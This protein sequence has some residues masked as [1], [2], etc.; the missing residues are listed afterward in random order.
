M[1]ENSPARLWSLRAAY[2]GLAL[3][4]FFVHLLPMRI[5]PPGIAGPDLLTALTFAWALRRPDYVPMLSIAIVMLLAD[6]LFQRPPGLWALLVLLASEWLK[7]RGRH[8]RE[9]TFAAEWL[10]AASAL[11]VIT[12]IYRVA[13][14][15]LIVTPGMLSLWVMQYGMTVAAYPLVAAISYLALGVRRSTPGEYD[16]TGRPL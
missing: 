12:V 16:H 8:V 5:V 1:A 7:L 11:L 4:I 10:T 14:A 15:L 6:F 2:G 13:L 3:A 9:N